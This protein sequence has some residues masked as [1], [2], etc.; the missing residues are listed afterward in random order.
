LFVVEAST[1][2]EDRLLFTNRFSLFARGEGGF[3]GDRG[4]PQPVPTPD[5][6]PDAEIASPTLPL[7][8]ALY[9]LSGDKNPLHIDPEYAR[10]GGFERPI[11][12]GLATFGAACKAVVDRLLDGQTERV[13][14]FRVRF[15]GIVLPGETIVTSAWRHD[16]GFLVSATT[17]ERGE[18]VLTRG[19]ISLR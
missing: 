13:R 15:S 10:I 5:G 4:E 1:R 11:L 12:H 17:A 2:L 9:R 6:S 8:A 3:G 7:Q 18:P 14:A 16:D 19:V